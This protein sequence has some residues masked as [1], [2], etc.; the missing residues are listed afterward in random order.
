MH[1]G[2]PACVTEPVQINKCQSPSIF[3]LYTL[4]ILTFENL[5]TGGKDINI[6]VGRG[7]AT[8]GGAVEASKVLERESALAREG[9]R[10]RESARER[11][12]L[13]ERE[14]ER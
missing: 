2:C 5:R 7:D 11:E 1:T 4:C 8:Q 14:R 10:A 6:R 13:S 9:A 3:T 12:R